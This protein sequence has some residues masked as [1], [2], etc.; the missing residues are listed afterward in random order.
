VDGAYGA[1][2]ALALP[3]KFRGLEQADSLSLD[4]HKWFYQPV[5]CGCLLF[6]DPAA[7][8]TAFAHTGDYAKSLNENPEESFSFFEESIELSRRFRALKLWVALRYHGREAFG[9]AIRQDIAHIRRLADQ[10]NGESTLELLAP[11]ELSV[12]CFRVKRAGLSHDELNGLNARVLKRVIERRRVYFSNATLR[13]TFALRCCF[14]NH[15]TTDEDVDAIV[16]EV[17]A[18]AQEVGHALA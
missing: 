13:G 10:I 16:K 3:E 5:D 12:V 17:L 1:L 8:R 9:E 14:V 6:R 7:A 4:P 18:A 2:A 11:V 15:R